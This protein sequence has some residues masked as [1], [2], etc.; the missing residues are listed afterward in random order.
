MAGIASLLRSARFDG[1]GKSAN[2]R[3]DASE[4][5]AAIASSIEGDGTSGRGVR[6]TSSCIGRD[7]DV[8]AVQ[9]SHTEAALTFPRLR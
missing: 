2:V 4:A 9:I 5:S 6:D 8:T 7:I 1:I 3:V